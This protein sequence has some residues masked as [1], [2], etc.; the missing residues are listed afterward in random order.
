MKKVCAVFLFCALFLTG[1]DVKEMSSLRELSRPYVGEYRCNKLT[2]GGEDLLGRFEAIKLTLTYF[3]DFTLCYTDMWKGEGEYS[4]RYLAEEDSVLFLIPS[5][6]EEKRYRFP[7]E[8]GK[9]L[10]DLPLGEKLLHA[11]FAFPG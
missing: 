2:L 8:E 7:Y 11:E 5:G 4:G 6:G 1:C 10:V 3:G 9:I